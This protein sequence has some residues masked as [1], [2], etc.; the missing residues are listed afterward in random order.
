MITHNSKAFLRDAI[1]SLLL[2]PA[3]EARTGIILAFA[4]QMLFD[5]PALL[6]AFM[7]RTGKSWRL[8][9]ISL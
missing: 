9:R 8:P 6:G 5:G 4:G 7:Q 1:E 2:L 3:F